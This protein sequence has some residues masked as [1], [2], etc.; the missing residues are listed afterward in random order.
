MSLNNLGV[1][2]KALTKVDVQGFV[3]SI[4]K[5]TFCQ[6]VSA[7][8]VLYERFVNGSTATCQTLKI[9]FYKQRMPH[10]GGYFLEAS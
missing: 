8:P 2:L 3:S 5:K 6:G 1:V 4:G 7:G 9:M 10:F